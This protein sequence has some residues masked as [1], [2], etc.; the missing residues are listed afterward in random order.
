MD[1]PRN[2]WLY[3]DEK[4]NGFVKTTFKFGK[5]NGDALEDIIGTRDGRWYVENVMLEFDD[6][7]PDMRAFL[8][9]ALET[10]EDPLNLAGTASPP[11]TPARNRLD[12]LKA[13]SK[14][15]VAARAAQ[16]K[17]K[18]EVEVL[19]KRKDEADW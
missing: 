11:T 1:L 15:K 17:Q 7:P 19:E 10:G 18:A 4:G 12:E 8:E 5:Y 6:M 9:K 13:K 14:A 16:K 2:R 3:A